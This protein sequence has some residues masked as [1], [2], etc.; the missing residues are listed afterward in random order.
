[1]AHLNPVANDIYDYEHDLVPY[2]GEANKPGIVNLHDQRLRVVCEAL[3]H[4]KRRTGNVRAS[5]L[6]E[7]IITN[8]PSYK[9]VLDDPSSLIV[10]ASAMTFKFTRADHPK[11][12]F[13]SIC[14]EIVRDLEECIPCFVQPG[15]PI[16]SEDEETIIG[17]TPVDEDPTYFYC[18]AE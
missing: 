11:M 7:H 8:R 16:W 15:A 3:F 12:T 10:I 9:E 18:N 6:F 1:M 4:S 2:R 17:H 14:A 5:K 13:E